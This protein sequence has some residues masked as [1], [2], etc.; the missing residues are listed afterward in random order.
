[1]KSDGVMWPVSLYYIALQPE[2][3]KYASV[4]RSLLYAFFA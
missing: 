3:K 2:N 1:M 4:L